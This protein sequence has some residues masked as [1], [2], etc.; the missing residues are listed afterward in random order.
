MAEVIEK[1]L[2]RR[3]YETLALGFRT[4]QSI[5]PVLDSEKLFFCPN[6]EG[7]F[8]WPTSE[9]Q[10]EGTAEMRRVYGWLE[11]NGWRPEVKKAKTDWAGEYMKVY[12]R[13]DDMTVL[14]HGWMAKTCRVVTEDVIIP[15]KPAQAA[16]PERVEKRRRIVCENT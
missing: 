14:L 6:S 9:G 16:Q 12:F 7:L 4:A 3:Q 8:V 2:G 11:L 13:K 15:A 1:T 5:E 10:E